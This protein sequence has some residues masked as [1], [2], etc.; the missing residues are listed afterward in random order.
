MSPTCSKYLEARWINYSFPT[1][2]TKTQRRNNCQLIRELCC[3]SKLITYLWKLQTVVN[4]FLSST[5]STVS[6]LFYH[7]FNI[8][9]AI[10]A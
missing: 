2:K 10:F 9:W 1:S 8:S 3:G 6:K 7:G 4:L 5:D